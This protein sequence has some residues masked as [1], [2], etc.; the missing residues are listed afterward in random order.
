[1]LQQTGRCASVV[2]C[3]RKVYTPLLTVDEMPSAWNG[4]AL[5]NIENAMLAAATSLGMGAGVAAVKEGLRSF[6]MSME[7]TPG[8]LNVYDE[9]PFRVIIDYAH[10]PPR[11]LLDYLRVL[12]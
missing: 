5:F 3:E 8:R 10:N 7:N 6:E 2:L 4:A 9:L 1:M 12:H 11:H